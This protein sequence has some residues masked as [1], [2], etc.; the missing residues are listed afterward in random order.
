MHI[1]ALSYAQAHS[2]HRLPCAHSPLGPSHIL[3]CGELAVVGL[4]GHYA[5]RVAQPLDQRGV[6]GGYCVGLDRVVR[7]QEQLAVKALR[8]LRLPQPL[9]ARRADDPAGRY[10]LD[11]L[12]H[13]QSGQRCSVLA[14]GGDH[15]LQQPL[16]NK[17]PHGVVYQDHIGGAGLLQAP[18][19]G[20]AA[21]STPGHKGG[22]LG[23]V[24]ARAQLAAAIVHVLAPHDQDDIGHQWASFEAR[25]YVPEYGPAS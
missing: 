19:H 10:F 23:K 1:V 21:L 3:G 14:S 22:D 15:P 20:C 8:G 17:R 2:R 5:N 4:A 6:I 9:A 25:E 18:I 24:S 13:R 16:R 12:Y 11:R 7:H